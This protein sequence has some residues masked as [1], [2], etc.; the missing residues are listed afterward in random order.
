MEMGQL[1]LAQLLDFAGKVSVTVALLGFIYGMAIKK[2]WV[3]GWLLA[4][5]DERIQR[6][7]GRVERYEQLFTRTI[8]PIIPDDKK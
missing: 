2:W 4:E 6:L 5:R 8:Q 3:P 1:T 7:E